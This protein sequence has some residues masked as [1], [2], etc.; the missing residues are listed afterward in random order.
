MTDPSGGFTRINSI[1]PTVH[2]GR[3]ILIL[4]MKKLRHKWTSN[5]PVVTPSMSDREGF[6]PQGYTASLSQVIFCHH[7]GDLSGSRFL[8]STCLQPFSR[9]GDLVESRGN[10]CP[11]PPHVIFSP[12]LA[13]SGNCIFSRPFLLHFGENNL[14]V[15]LKMKRVLGSG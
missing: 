4:Q 10:L 3:T 5:L 11:L 6:K 13:D 9:F 14:L 15:N 7:P 2:D 8:N 12:Y 1:F